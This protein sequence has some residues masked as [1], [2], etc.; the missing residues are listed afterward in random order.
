MD[1]RELAAA[2]AGS[3]GPQSARAVVAQPE[4]RPPATSGSTPIVLLAVVVVGVVATVGMNFS[5]LIPAFAQDELGSDA[6]G[7]GFLMAASGVGSLL[8]AHAARVR[9][10][11]ASRSAS[12]PGR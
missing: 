6:A 7:Y 2:G 8:A 5:V 11:A 12:R 3:T 4:G 9:W 10:A 1:E